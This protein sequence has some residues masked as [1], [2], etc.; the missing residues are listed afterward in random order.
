MHL[1]EKECGYFHPALC[2]YGI[3]VLKNLQ[4]V[5][6][7]LAFFFLFV[8]AGS[9][10]AGGSSAGMAPAGSFTHLESLTLVCTCGAESILNPVILA[11]TDFGTTVDI[12]QGGGSRWPTCVPQHLL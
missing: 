4:D 12:S 8:L 11:S 1:F 6:F 9:T 3:S 7:F 10:Q 2:A 5:F